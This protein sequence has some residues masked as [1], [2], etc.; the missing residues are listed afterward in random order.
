M[1]TTVLRRILA[2]GVAA[3]TAFLLSA[4]PA[5]ADSYTP[6]EQM[7]LTWR[8]NGYNTNQQAMDFCR[9]AGYGDGPLQC[10]IVGFHETKRVAEDANYER[11]VSEYVYSCPGVSGRTDL[12]FS[13]TRTATFSTGTT[14]ATSLSVKVTVAPFGVGADVTA[15]LSVAESFNW[16]WGSASTVSQT[17]S[18][19]TNPGWVHWIDYAVDHGTARGILSVRVPGELS[20]PYLG[21]MRGGYFQFPEEI[22]G[23][24]P[25]ST[26]PHAKLL[27]MKRGYVLDGRPMTSYEME[28]CEVPGISPIPPILSASMG[29]STEIGK[30]LHAA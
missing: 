29:G 22:T 25:K 10:Q 4:T 24:L 6:V 18:I 30:V 16:S 19:T 27:Q 14:V 15:S 13:N 5:S 26:D 12:S 23:D 3:G 8:P 9:K 28:R 21:R 1:N 2:L 17:Y 11:R 20:S 7:I